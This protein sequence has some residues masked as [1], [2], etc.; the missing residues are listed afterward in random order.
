MQRWSLATAAEME[1]HIEGERR[2]SAILM[3]TALVGAVCQ[4]I[5]ALIEVGRSAGWWQ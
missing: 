3:V 5:T 4:A 1:T 2:F